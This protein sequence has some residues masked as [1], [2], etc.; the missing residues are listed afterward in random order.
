MDIM[1]SEHSTCGISK[2]AWDRQKDT[3]V[4]LGSFMKKDETEQL[5]A[6]VV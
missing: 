1:S 6:C 5:A 4:S 2:A 3:K